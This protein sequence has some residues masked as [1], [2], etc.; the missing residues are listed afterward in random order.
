MYHCLSIWPLTGQSD[1]FLVD[2]NSTLV[3]HIEGR[4]SEQSPKKVNLWEDR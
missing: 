2:M 4:K 1:S 3:L